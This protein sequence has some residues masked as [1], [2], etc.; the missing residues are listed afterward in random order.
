[1]VDLDGEDR[2]RRISASGLKVLDT[3]PPED[4]P[5]VLQ[6]WKHVSNIETEPTAT[7]GQEHPEALAEVDRQWL[8]QA[9]RNSLFAEDGSFLVSM[10]GQ[11]SLELGWICVEWS[12]G[13]ELASHLQDEGSPEFLGMSIDGDHVCAVTTEEYEY[14]IVK[15]RFGI[16]SESLDASNPGIIREVT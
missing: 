16:Y 9:S 5:T 8:L 12:K 6:V 1:M 7:V 3:P 13:A 2:W 4:V 14:W 10:A 11:G 15:H